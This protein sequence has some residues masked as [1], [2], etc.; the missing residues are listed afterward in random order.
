MNEFQTFFNIIVGICGALAGWVLN[1][2]TKSID[3]L[4]QDVRDMPH[5]YVSKDDYR[6]DIAEI[7]V[8]LGEIY[9]ELRLK[10]DK[11]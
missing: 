5:D 7:K 6:S 8:M 10:A 3:R 4:D 1:N 9:K 11:Q 2:I